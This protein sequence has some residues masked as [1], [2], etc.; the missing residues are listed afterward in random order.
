MRVKTHCF[1]A[2]FDLISTVTHIILGITRIRYAR[3]LMMQR[4]RSSSFCTLCMASSSNQRDGCEKT[5]HNHTV[6]TSIQK[7]PKMASAAPQVNYANYPLKDIPQPHPHDV[8]CGRG[9]GTNNHIGNSHWRM[10]V[11][12]N[13]QLYITLPKR[14]KMLLS[15][16][17]VNAVRSQNPPGRFLQKDSKSNKW[18]DVGDQRAQEKTSQALREGAPDIRKKVASAKEDSVE[19]TG[20][21]TEIPGASSSEKN[22]E[23]TASKDDK[24]GDPKPADTT[25]AA[26]NPPAAATS[27]AKQPSKTAPQAPPKKPQPAAAEQQQQPQGYPQAAQ[28][29]Q[30]QHMPHQ[31]VHPQQAMMN[32]QFMGQHPGMGQHPNMNMGNMGNM[33]QFGQNM[34][35][36]MQQPFHPQQVMAGQQQGMNFQQQQQMMQFNGMQLFP[37]MV[38]NENG[39]MVPAMSVVPQGGMQNSNMQNMHQQQMM[40]PPQAMQ[41]QGNQRQYKNDDFEPLPHNPNTSSNNKGQSNSQNRNDG[42]RKQAP[43]FDALMSGAAVPPEAG[44]ETTGISFGSM[45]MTDAEMRRLQNMRASMTSGQGG[46]GEPL[47]VALDG[48]EPTGLSFGDV[49]MMS[50]GTKKLEEQGCSFGT[51]MSYQTNRSEFDTMKLEQIG[52]SFG[53]LSLDTTNRDTLFH[54]LELAAAGPEIPPMFETEKKATGNLLECSDTESET[55]EEKNQLK[56]Q[57]SQQWDKMQ[58]SLI[59]QSQKS[60]G[61]AGSTDL[62]PPPVDMKGSVLSVPTTNFDRDFSQLSA[63]D[64]GDDSHHDGDDEGAAAAPPPPQALK[65]QGSDEGEK[66]EMYMLQ[67]YDKQKG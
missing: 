55:E 44:L 54:Q 42:Q 26:V 57:K 11:A 20:A 19:S 59:L 28:K 61:T 32:Q 12:A 14:Q 8:L 65:K 33:G 53:S 64:F 25:S 39:V 27:N 40:P 17:I 60:K 29:Q 16:S 34:N 36:A 56:A 52:T 63:Y 21:A 41:N 7:I 9:G 58:A 18:F 2:V 62:M 23:K 67:Q 46:D 50:V 35:G 15:R 6:S 10:L 66:L 31:Q 43:D 51:M 5:R 22:P 49:S 4:Q 13:K 47:P 1:V 38:L 30:P 37:T 48:L 45:G 24:K 3:T